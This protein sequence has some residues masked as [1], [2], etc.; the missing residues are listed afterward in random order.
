[1]KTLL[2]FSIFC[3][4]VLLGI[5]VEERTQLYE[6]S[7]SRSDTIIEKEWHGDLSGIR[8]HGTDVNPERTPLPTPRWP[9]VP[10]FAA[11]TST[12]D[13]LSLSKEPL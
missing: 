9:G 6:D 10:K 13:S 7:P 11:P 2:V 1:M 3:G 5:F 4:G 8:Y 12:P